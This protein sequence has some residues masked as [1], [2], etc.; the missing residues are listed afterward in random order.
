[1]V[2]L[3]TIDI[4]EKKCR[5]CK[6]KK[7]LREFCV[8]S[9]KK[10]GRSSRCK[11][12]AKDYYKKNKEK[13]LK[14]KK[15]YYK[16]N[17]TGIRRKFTEYRNNN[18]EKFRRM[19]KEEY[20]RNK[21][22]YAEYSK[23]YLKDKLKTDPYFKFKHQ[24]RCRLRIAIKKGYKVGSAVKDMGCTGREAYDYIASKFTEGM[25]WDNHGEWH[26]DHIKPLSSFNL[27]N[28]EQFLEA[29][30]YTNL[31]PLWAEDNHRKYDR[32][33]SY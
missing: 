28:R 8:N 20:H 17:K 25:S 6:I 16:V 7:D 22:K 3:K 9:R 12:C 21:E 19:K 29:V 31:Q 23:E 10:D 30:H 33:E 27:E 5:V 2:E 1:M 18:K 15:D 24:L 32:V 4:P 11:T 14:Q 13:V 26:I